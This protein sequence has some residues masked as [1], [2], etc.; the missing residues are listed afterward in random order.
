MYVCITHNS[1]IFN[2]AKKTEAMIMR[3]NEAMILGTTELDGGSMSSDLCIRNKLS[4]K[5]SMFEPK[6]K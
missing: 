4:Q 6:G 5:S 3:Q 1:F 2:C